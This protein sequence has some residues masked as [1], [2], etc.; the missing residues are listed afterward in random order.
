MR[1]AVANDMAGLRGG[2]L[3]ISK[4]PGARGFA[5]H[6]AETGSV[7]EYWYCWV[8]VDTTVWAFECTEMAIT[9]KGMRVGD[10]KLP[11]S[12]RWRG[13]CLVG[14]CRC[15]QHH[16]ACSPVGTSA[17]EGAARKHPRACGAH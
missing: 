1:A 8:S 6:D 5:V 7:Q 15:E 17:G 12:V 3:P 11:S 10:A 16:H 4:P 9:V 2:S 13:R 14:R